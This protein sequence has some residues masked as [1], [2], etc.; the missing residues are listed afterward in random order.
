MGH[1]L[2]LCYHAISPHW[3]SSLA[4]APDHFR[5]HLELLLRHGYR[6]VTFAQAVLGDAPQRAMAVTFD[7]G[8]RSVYD[9]AWPILTELGIPGTVF[10]PTALIGRPSPMSWPGID[11]WE[12]TPYENELEGMSWEELRQLRDAGWEIASHGQ[13][14]PNLPELDQ[15]ALADELTGSRDERQQR[16][17]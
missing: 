8:F 5:E 3:P 16:V 15:R 17:R 14:H 6:G 10:V 2:V 11:E 4:V 12:G 13:T 7:D 9:H 1:A